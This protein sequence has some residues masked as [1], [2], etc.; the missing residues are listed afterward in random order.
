[1]EDLEVLM[2]SVQVLEVHI[3][4]DQWDFIHIIFLLLY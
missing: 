4:V 1:M 3:L 2:V